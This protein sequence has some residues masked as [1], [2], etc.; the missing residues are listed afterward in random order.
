[1]STAPR[2]SNLLLRGFAPLVAAAVLILLVILLIP[3]V[4]PERNVEVERSTTST[5]ATTTSTVGVAP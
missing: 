2:S 3:S 1:M 4:A 5:T